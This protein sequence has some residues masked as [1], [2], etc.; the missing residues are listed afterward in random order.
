MRVCMGGGDRVYS[1]YTLY[2]PVVSAGG[3]GVCVRG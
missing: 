1:V 2:S 3:E